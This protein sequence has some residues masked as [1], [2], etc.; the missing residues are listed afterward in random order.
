MPR[1]SLLLA[2]LNFNLGVEAGQLVAV[3]VVLPLLI[4]LRKT[5]WERRVVR[6]LSALV[7][8]VGLGLFIERAAD[9]TPAL[10]WQRVG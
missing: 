10:M 5:R 3:A 9:L 1:E 8:V 2:L 4:W 6:A 7:L